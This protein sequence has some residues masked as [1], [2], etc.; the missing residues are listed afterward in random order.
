[1]MRSAKL[2]A[3]SPPSTRQRMV[4]PPPRVVPTIDSVMMGVLRARLLDGA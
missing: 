2:R 3:A 1:M 4:R